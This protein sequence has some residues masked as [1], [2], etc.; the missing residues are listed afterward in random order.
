VVFLCVGVKEPEK[1]KKKKK[2]IVPEETGRERH[3]TES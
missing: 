2:K 1:K 3:E